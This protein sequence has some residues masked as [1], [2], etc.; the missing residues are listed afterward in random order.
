MI[1][2][3]PVKVD[4]KACL[5]VRIN[6]PESPPL[7]LVIANKGFMMCGLLN[8]DVAEKFGA[9]AAMVVGVKT[10]EDVLNAEVK[11]VTSRAKALG[12]NV[13]TRGLEALRR[14]L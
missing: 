8:I 2:V 5:G 11:A 9:I 14:M 6:L 3:T 7:L 13:G 1:D 4:D 12:V 10:F